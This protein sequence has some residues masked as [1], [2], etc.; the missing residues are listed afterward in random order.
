MQA[1]LSPNVDS[2]EAQVKCH[3]RDLYKI[4]TVYLKWYKPKAENSKN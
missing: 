1:A 2:P 3:T 4:Y